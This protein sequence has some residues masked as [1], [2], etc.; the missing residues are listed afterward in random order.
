V[1]L[2]RQQ[3]VSRAIGGAE[4]VVAGLCTLAGWGVTGGLMTPVDLLALKSYSRLWLR[5]GLRLAV[6]IVG[7]GEVVRVAVIW[8]EVGAKL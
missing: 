5:L 8:V 3:R 7:C 2:R 6:D 4:V 1:G